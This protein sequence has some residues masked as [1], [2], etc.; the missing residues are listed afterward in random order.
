VPNYFEVNSRLAWHATKSFV[1]SLTGM[2]L[3]HAHHVEFDM[4]TGAVEIPRSFL[5][6]TQWRF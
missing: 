5:I 4:S 1:V 3:L 6:Q 2:N